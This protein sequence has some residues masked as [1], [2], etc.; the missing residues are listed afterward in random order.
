MVVVQHFV[1]LLRGTGQNY[2]SAFVLYG[3]HVVDSIV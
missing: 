2:Q 1:T 3:L